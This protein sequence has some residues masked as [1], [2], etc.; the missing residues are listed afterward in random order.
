M[1]CLSNPSNWVEFEPQTSLQH[2]VSAGIYSQLFLTFPAFPWEESE[3]ADLKLNIQKTK[4]M[5]AS[6][7]TSWQIDGGKVETVIDFIFLGPQ[8]TVDVD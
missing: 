6:P 8:I 5:A 7:I 3:K 4:I 1:K 2:Q